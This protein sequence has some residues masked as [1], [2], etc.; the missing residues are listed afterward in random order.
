MTRSEYRS[1]FRD[2][3]RTVA[4]TKAAQSRHPADRSVLVH[5]ALH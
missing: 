1:N 5:A 3:R 2:R 4:A